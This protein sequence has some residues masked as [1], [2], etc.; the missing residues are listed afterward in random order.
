MIDF[1]DNLKIGYVIAVPDSWGSKLIRVI[2]KYSQTQ[3][4]LCATEIEAL[5]ISA[6]LNLSGVLSV[7]IMENSGIRSIGDVLTRFELA[8]NIHNI[9]LLSD[10]G[11]F[12][13]PNWWGVKHTHVTDSIL[14]DLSIATI[15]V[16]SFSEFASALVLAIQTFRSEQVS[17]AIKLKKS[18]WDGLP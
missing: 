15:E 13:E 9:F 11:G 16:F 12:G 2:K 1:F 6:G 5:T 17:V 3:V 18:F 10:R 7:I 8:H 4:L 14:K